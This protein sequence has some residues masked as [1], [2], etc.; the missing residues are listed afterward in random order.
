[1][2]IV[3][4][5]LYCTI[6]LVVIWFAST[7]FHSV[8]VSLTPLPWIIEF[9]VYLLVLAGILIGLV[10]GFLA[11]LRNK[12]NNRRQMRL[13]RRNYALLETE[14]ARRKAAGSAIDSALLSS[15]QSK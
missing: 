1:M 3:R 9:P 2:T 12:L 10:F 14:M 13:L 8:I 6:V 7:N 15:D 11:S 5:P 4:W